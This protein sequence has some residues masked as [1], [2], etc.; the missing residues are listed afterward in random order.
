MQKMIFIDTSDVGAD[1]SA[2]AAQALGFEPVFLID[3]DEFQGDTVQQV[4]QYKYFHA[5]T[6]SVPELL[7]VIEQHNL[8]NIEG[9]IS[10]LDSGI[11]IA[12][13]LA[14]RLNVTS[15]PPILSELASKAY[16]A[17]L[18][19]E[20]SP[21]SYALS[22]QQLE[23]TQTRHFLK[24]H[25]QL[26][27]KPT[28][29]AGGVG[30]KQLSSQDIEGLTL[31]QHLKQY[32]YQNWIVME[33]VEG[34]LYSLEGFVHHDEVHFLGFT[35]RRNIG[36][37]ESYCEFPVD[38]LIPLKLQRIAQQAI[39]ALAKRSHYA[40]G[41]FHS[42]FLITQT[43][44]YL[45]DA[46]LG[47]IGGGALVDMLSASY[48]IAPVE[49]MQHFIMLSLF[50]DQT[51]GSPYAIDTVLKSCGIN[52]GI[53]QQSRLVTIHEDSSSQI[54]HTRLLGNGALVPAM[55]TNNFAW[56]GI[57]SGTQSQ[58]NEFVDKMAIQT[59][60]GVFKPCY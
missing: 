50:L 58:V 38:E 57:I 22:T 18:V 33:Y 21:N 35:S 52:Y 12:I 39:K 16:V 19:P 34:D 8:Q 23:N 56:I 45:I 53:P 47:R 11:P 55:G 32:P 51:S 14:D 24:K 20:Y 4:Q 30:V 43:E 2:Q 3:L 37:T 49:V 54:N 41:Y 9:V 5:D 1:Y 26:L 48:D 27:V 25:E 59:E 36:N 46:N 42:E 7:N 13:Q 17:E 29:A 6:Q 60:S 31:T 40:N 28:N 10:T 15:M 44:C